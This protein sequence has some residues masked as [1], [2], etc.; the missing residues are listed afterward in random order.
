MGRNWSADDF[1]PERYE[2]GLAYV[3]FE[4]MQLETAML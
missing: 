3:G 1:V 2:H 4:M